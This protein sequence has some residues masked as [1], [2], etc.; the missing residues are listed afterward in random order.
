MTT[1]ENKRK[2]T[3]IEITRLK[4]RMKLTKRLKGNKYLWGDM[5]YVREIKFTHVE[6]INIGKMTK[7]LA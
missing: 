5:E 1:I 6:K 4:R 7:R 2:A 3:G